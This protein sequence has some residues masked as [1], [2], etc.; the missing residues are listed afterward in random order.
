DVA[1]L[2][3][4]P[5]VRI[6]GAREVATRLRRWFES[7]R[8]HAEKLL[9]HAEVEVT[10]APGGL[11]A[12]GTGRLKLSLFER[13]R[14]ETTPSRAERLRAYINARIKLVAVAGAIKTLRTLSDAMLPTIQD[15]ANVTRCLDAVVDRIG[16][17]SGNAS[18]NCASHAPASTTDEAAHG[19]AAR[20]SGELHVALSEQQNDLVRRLDEAVRQDWLD[21]RGGLASLVDVEPPSIDELAAAVARHAR[22]IV[23]DA[24]IHLDVAGKIVR[25]AGAPEY[26]DDIHSWLCGLQPP[27]LDVGGARAFLLASGAATDGTPLQELVERETGGQC[28]MIAHPDA[29]LA[30]VCCGEQLSLAGIV[31]WLAREPG[32][33]EIATQLH[34][35]IDV[36]WKSI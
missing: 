26:Q 35:R 4:N 10:Q 31:R 9:Q 19:L 5:E 25:L 1:R 3:D 6:L 30:L 34:T 15:V 20:L 33:V 11:P 17:S 29:G 18:D 21:A 8:Q 23:T 24:I 16:S 13:R 32:I 22:A 27:A 14:D 2:V 36:P 12:P 28:S 7:T